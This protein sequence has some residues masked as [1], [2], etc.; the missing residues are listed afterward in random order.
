MHMYVIIAYGLRSDSRK[1]F[2]VCPFDG[3]SKGLSY[4]QGSLWFFIRTLWLLVNRTFIWKKIESLQ[5]SLERNE[6][7]TLKRGYNSKN[8]QESLQFWEVYLYGDNG[9]TVFKD[10]TCT[11]DNRGAWK[12]QKCFFVVIFQRFPKELFSEQFL[13][14]PLFSLKP[15]TFFSTKNLLFSGKVLWML[16]VLHKTM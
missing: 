7:F 11:L 3:T 5:N 8:V 15:E 10:L 1:T 12:N 13:K 4:T 2:N 9:S 14:E 16:K 6:A